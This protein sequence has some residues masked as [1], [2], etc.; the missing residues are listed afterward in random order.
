M[1][2]IGRVSDK[3]GR[4]RL[5]L[6]ATLVNIFLQCIMLT[7]KNQ[8]LLTVLIYLLGV[9][10]PLNFDLTYIYL[11]ELIPQS[12]QTFVGSGMNLVN[13]ACL[14]YGALQLLVFTKKC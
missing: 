5:V 2:W 14:G 6:P 3:Y 4:K 1:A 9:L 8:A 13:C 11:Y 10:F 12:S 7:T